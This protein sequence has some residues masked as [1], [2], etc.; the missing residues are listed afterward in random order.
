MYAA[1]C[2]LPQGDDT[3][4]ETLGTAYSTRAAT[5]PQPF[6]LT[7]QRPRPLPVE[8]PPPP[9]LRAK[10]APRPREGPTREEEALV[11]ARAA[12]KEAALRKAAKWVGWGGGG[13]GKVGGAA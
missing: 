9:P 6:N 4:K 13:G 5:V 7:Q 11:A 8:D 1:P 10:P 3:D 2:P 12:N